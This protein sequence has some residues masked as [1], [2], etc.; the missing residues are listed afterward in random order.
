M[1]PFGQKYQEILETLKVHILHKHQ[2]NMDR[3]SMKSYSISEQTLR[4]NAVL[5]RDESVR[6]YIYKIINILSEITIMQAKDLQ[7]IDT[8]THIQN[9]VELLETLLH[10]SYTHYYD[11]SYNL[12]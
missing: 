4:T 1:K 11:I 12:K 3:E 9:N 2:K 8:N 7:T 10:T 6:E 5:V